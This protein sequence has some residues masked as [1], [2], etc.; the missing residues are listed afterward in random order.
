MNAEHSSRQQK[1]F[2]LCPPFSREK[3]NDEIYNNPPT[4]D[5][6]LTAL[7]RP[8]SP[9][10]RSSKRPKRTRL[11]QKRVEP[12]PEFVT[13]AMC[14]DDYVDIILVPCGHLTT[15]LS[16]ANEWAK[17]HRGKR[18]PCPVCKKPVVRAVKFFDAGVEVK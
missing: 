2:L 10:K 16:C 14:Y 17:K 7:T 15:C 18:M 6:L 3:R 12:P 13:C 11:P 4:S 8:A 5:P 1:K 9:V